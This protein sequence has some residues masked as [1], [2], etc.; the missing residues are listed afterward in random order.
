M[1]LYLQ[2]SEVPR[3]VVEKLDRLKLCHSYKSS[4]SIIKKLVEHP[5]DL[6]PLPSPLSILQVSEYFCGFVALAPAKYL[7]TKVAEPSLISTNFSDITIC[8]MSDSS[9]DPCAL[10]LDVDH[11]NYFCGSIA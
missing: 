10:A 3:R 7:D 8:N 5:K 2:G 11:Q 1:D 4:N 6:S 9:G